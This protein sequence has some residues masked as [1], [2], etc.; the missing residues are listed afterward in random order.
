[1]GEKGKVIS[2]ELIPELKEMGERNVAKYSFITK[3]VAKFICADGSNGYSSKAPFD[4]ILSSASSKE[5]IPQA[6]KDQLKIGGRIVAPIKSSIW[7]FIKRS[8]EEFEER[9]H[10]GFA[11]VPLI[12]KN[13]EK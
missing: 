6:W 2:I 7:L 3:R 1:V 10:P 5:K 9:E 13:E 11:F 12:E 8:K 4:K